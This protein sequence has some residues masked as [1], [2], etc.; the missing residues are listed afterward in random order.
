MHNS[1]FIIGTGTDIEDVESSIRCELDGWGTEDNW[2]DIIRTVDLSEATED[3][4]KYIQE[5]L[6]EFNAEF[7]N[8]NIKKI[9]NRIEEYKELAKD[10]PYYYE[11]ISD[12]YKKLSELKTHEGKQYT[13]KD[14]KSMPDFF[15]YDFDRWGI[16]SMDFDESEDSKLFF[17]EIDMHS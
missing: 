15:G 5:V 2:S 17:T 8:E 16:T 4:K 6:D 12:E 9:E 13:F 10:K 3:D 11:L 7:T 14:V 1:H